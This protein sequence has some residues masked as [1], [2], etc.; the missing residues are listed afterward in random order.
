MKTLVNIHQTPCEKPHHKFAKKKDQYKTRHM[1]R[2][3]RSTN[4]ALALKM[5]QLRKSPISLPLTQLL[6]RS[7]KSSF[8]QVN[9]LNVQ[10]EL[11]IKKGRTA[12]TKANS[13][14]TSKSTNAAKDKKRT[15][16]LSLQVDTKKGKR[17]SSK[18]NV[19]NIVAFAQDKNATQN[20]KRNLQMSK[21]KVTTN[22][23]ETPAAKLKNQQRKRKHISEVCL[24]NEVVGSEVNE[25]R[26]TSST[27]A[28]V[29]PPLRKSARLSKDGNNDLLT[30]GTV[31]RITLRKRNTRYTQQRSVDTFSP[32]MTRSRLKELMQKQGNP[33][34]MDGSTQF[35]A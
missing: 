7:R 12:T 33:F 28:S 4:T 20:A 34:V 19:I 5:Q 23:D 9:K 11:I 2:R 26:K 35:I 24:A 21:S 6:L 29:M 15:A 30:I 14:T 22:V 3:G 10:T 16:A 31:K 1:A 18:S 17:N 8:V 25:M 27:E 32:P 13:V